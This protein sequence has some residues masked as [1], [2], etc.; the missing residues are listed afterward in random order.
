MLVIHFRTTQSAGAK[1]QF[2]CVIY[3]IYDTESLNIIFRTTK[4]PR[5]ENMT[6]M[7]LTFRELY[8]WVTKISSFSDL[9]T[10]FT[11]IKLIKLKFPWKFHHREPSVIL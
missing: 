11:M 7:D 5:M 3:P 10:I 4:S 6:L 9:F 1:A 2:T 8:S